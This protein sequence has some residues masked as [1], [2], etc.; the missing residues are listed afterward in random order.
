MPSCIFF[1]VVSYKSFVVF[2][3]VTSFSHFLFTIQSPNNSKA[4]KKV[5][6]EMS[7]LCHFQFLKPTHSVPPSTKHK[8]RNCLPSCILLQHIVSYFSYLTILQPYLL[9]ILQICSFSQ[10]KGLEY[11][12]PPETSTLPLY[13][14]FPFKYHCFW[15]AFLNPLNKR[16]SSLI[17]F[18]YFFTL[19][20]LYNSLLSFSILCYY[21]FKICNIYLINQAPW[22]EP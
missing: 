20:S 12:Y 7:A 9:W 10:F 17:Y 19:Y 8:M 14:I 18:L 13:F 16:D 11:V 15:K 21:I 22:G 3:W 2:Y 1:G 4:A 6:L 5:H